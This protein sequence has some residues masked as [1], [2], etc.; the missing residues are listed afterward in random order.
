MDHKLALIKKVENCFC[1]AEIFFERKLLRPKVLFN[2]RGQDA[3]RAYF[4]ISRKAKKAMQVELR[5]NEKL[6]DRNPEDFINKVVPHECAHLIV[7]EL[8]GTK[9]KPHGEEWKVVMEKLFGVKAEVTHDFDTEDIVNKPFIYKCAC[10]NR[11]IAFTPRQHKQIAKGGQYICRACRSEVHFLF[12]KQKNNVK[13]KTENGSIK[14]L[15]VFQ[16]S[17]NIVFDEKLEIR[18]NYILN[19]KKPSQIFSSGFSNDELLKSWLRINSL[20]RKYKGEM[21]FRNLPVLVEQGLVSHVLLLV[22]DVDELLEEH[23][24]ILQGLRVQG[25]ITRTLRC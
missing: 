2:I 9:V 16:Q 8:F 17:E 4:P 6:L 14:G 5:F 12:E 13:R 19:R 18:L 20:I 7:Y 23:A 15:F 3:G 1:D 21:L 10:E 22:D 25:V 24:T 11:K